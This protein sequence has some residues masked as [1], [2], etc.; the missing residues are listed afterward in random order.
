V[1]KHQAHMAAKVKKISSDFITNPSSD[2]LAA[3]QNNLLYITST[4][5]E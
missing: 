5:P 1:E 4:L 2:Q 3:I